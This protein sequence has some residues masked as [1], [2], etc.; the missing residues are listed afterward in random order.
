MA[1]KTAHSKGRQIMCSRRQLRW[2]CTNGSELTLPPSYWSVTFSTWLCHSNAL[3]HIPWSAASPQATCP[4]PWGGAGRG[5]QTDRQTRHKRH[6]H[7]LQEVPTVSEHS[8]VKNNTWNLEIMHRNSF[9]ML[10]LEGVGVTSR[11]CSA[12]SINRVAPAVPSRAQGTEWASCCSLPQGKCSECITE[13]CW[14]CTPSV[15]LSSLSLQLSVEVERALPTPTAPS[16]L[17]CVRCWCWNF[18]FN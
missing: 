2:S 12:A 11:K 18:C 3:L 6:A 17:T 15:L 5:G 4:S 16:S 8:M 10:F 14:K 7:E 13:P 1:A 9:N